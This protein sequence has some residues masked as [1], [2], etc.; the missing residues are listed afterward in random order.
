MLR[1]KGICYRCGKTEAELGSKLSRDQVI[2]DCLFPQP[3]GIIPKEVLRLTGPAT[4]R[5]SPPKA[6]HHHQKHQRQHHRHRRRSHLLLRRRRFRG[7]RRPGSGLVTGLPLKRLLRRTCCPGYP[8]YSIDGLRVRSADKAAEKAT[9][10]RGDVAQI[11][12]LSARYSRD[13]VA[14]LTQRGVIASETPNGPLQLVFTAK[15]APRWMP[16]LFPEEP[17]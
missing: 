17:R 10:P 7:P 9:V 14:E 2:A 4:P 5:S 12:G 11:L 13:T 1:R 15:L 8:R 3:S 16:S 6:H